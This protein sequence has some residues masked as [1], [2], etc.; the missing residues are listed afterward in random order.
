MSLRFFDL[1]FTPE[2]LA[3]Q[4]QHYGRAQVLPPHGQDDVLGPSE[5]EFIQRRDSFYIASVSSTGW[6]Y[7]QHRGGPP[8]FLR[9]LPAGELAFAD[10]H[11]NRQ[12]LTTGNTATNDRVCLFLMDYPRRERLKILGHAS[13]LDARAHPD[14]VEAVAPGALQKATGSIVRI[15]VA[16][17]DWNCPKYITP[18]HTD[19]E[20]ESVVA[21]LR[22]RIAELEAR[23]AAE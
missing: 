18:R 11:G 12:M 8:G 23:L 13:V 15:R 6:P 7:V 16:A 20:V 4:Q 1:T 14:L 9:V 10:F 21:P 5:I 3:A 19:T 17:Y 2:V 22:A